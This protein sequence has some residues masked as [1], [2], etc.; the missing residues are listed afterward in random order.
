MDKNFEEA[1]RYLMPPTGSFWRWDD[2]GTVVVW[3]SG[4][5]IAFREELAKVLKRLAPGGLPAIDAVLLLIA[6]TRAYWETDSVKLRQ[7]LSRSS[8]LPLPGITIDPTTRLFR[9]LDLVHKLP[10]RLTRTPDAK[11]DI[12][13]IVFEAAPRWVSAEVA[14]VVCEVLDKKLN[15]AVGSLTRSEGARNQTT[16]SLLHDC[17]PLKRG[18]D[19]L[20]ADAIDLWRRTGLLSEPKPALND[21]PADQLS[22]R[23]LLLNL[24]NDEEFAGL[25]R[26]ARNLAAVVSLPRTITDTDELP[27]GGVSDITNRGT[28]DRLLLSELAHDDLMLATRLALNEALY[29]RRESPPAFPPKQRHVLIDCGLRMWGVPRVFSTAVALSLAATTEQGAALCAYRASGVDI[30]PIDL[31]SRE[32][33]VTHLESLEPEVHPGL[34]LDEF[35]QHVRQSD[36]AGDVVLVTTDTVLADLDFQQKLSEADAPPIYLATVDREGHFQLW[37]RGPRGRKCHVNLQLDLDVLFEPPPRPSTK[38]IQTE[39]D[40][41]LPAILHVKPFPF[42][43]PYGNGNGFK[44]EV[45]WSVPRRQSSDFAAVGEIPIVA[46]FDLKQVVKDV[47]T[48]YRQFSSRNS[49]DKSLE[50]GVFFLTRDHTLLLFDESDRGALQFGEKLPFGKCV[51]SWSGDEVGVSYALIYRESD[52]VIYLFSINLMKSEVQ[53]DP[54]PS[55]Y[56]KPGG[57]RSQVFGAVANGSVLFVIYQST[58]EAFDIITKGLIHQTHCEMT[59][60]GFKQ[61]FF[62]NSAMCHGD[63]WNTLSYDGSAIQLQYVPL[64]KYLSTSSKLVLF[65]RKGHD[66]PFA[67]SQGLIINLTEQTERVFLDQPFLDVTL[68]DI[69]VDG[70][71]A[72]IR[73]FLQ[74]SFVPEY[75]IIDTKTALTKTVPVADSLAHYDALQ[76]N[77][78]LLPMRRIT[79]AYVEDGHLCIVSN[80]HMRWK[81]EGSHDRLFLVQSSS[82]RKYNLSQEFEPIKQAEPG[83]SLRVAK[84]ADGSRLWID[85]RGLMHLQSSD[86]LIPEATF[87]LNVSGVAVWTSDGKMHG[88]SYYI[89]PSRPSISAEQVRDLIL[90]P[91]IERL[92]E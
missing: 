42:R 5:T 10:E 36:L 82:T 22:T 49:T 81:F 41:N 35:F 69:D 60:K 25:S 78:G 34:S 77:G 87:M 62:F 92:R 65:D 20:T 28:L 17:E 72:L 58:I 61:R 33:L 75:R 13:A 4:S 53:V 51:Y 64:G 3:S 16:N 85:S 12:A 74:K 90:T 68:L 14:H 18:L 50:R 48:A 66:G 37:S 71:R 89:D 39:I 79:R 70:R 38:L 54:L 19:G 76:I 83:Y 32:G 44:N 29:L 11:G 27:M 73:L 91:F 2:Q 88:S 43:F 31:A 86:R 6:A 40:P 45:L 67:I 63:A 26:L 59:Y 55:S 15:Y 24:A 30:I 7:Y 21:S 47:T 80:R 57:S 84:W 52:A 23:T 1:L 56:L 8:L 9:G 46:Q